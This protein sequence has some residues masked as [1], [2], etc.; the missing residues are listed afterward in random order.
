MFS[1]IW[2]NSYNTW[3]KGKQVI[4]NLLFFFLSLFIGCDNYINV[5]SNA[6]R[7]VQAN[8]TETGITLCDKDQTWF[9][10]RLWIRFISDNDDLWIPQGCPPQNACNTNAPGS[11]YHGHPMVHGTVRRQ[12]YFRFGN[13]CLSNFLEVFVSNCKTF[14]VYKLLNFPV[15]LSCNYRI[16]AERG[17]SDLLSGPG[18]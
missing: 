3:E 18:P 11:L 16:C 4:T 17:K 15:N 8:S 2:M 12:I 9:R 10:K 14:F 7:S 1:P 6:S 13:K 5:T